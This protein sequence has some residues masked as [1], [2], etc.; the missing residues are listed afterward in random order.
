MKKLRLDV[1]AL[2]VSSFVPEKPAGRVHGMEMAP[3]QVAGCTHTGEAGCYPTK[4][5]MGPGCFTTA[6]YTCE[7][8]NNSPC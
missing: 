4:Y 1:A 2:E 3:T 8:A 5:C 7:T 6:A